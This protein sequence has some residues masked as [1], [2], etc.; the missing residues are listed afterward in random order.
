RMSSHRHL[1]ISK[2]IENLNDRRSTTMSN[3]TNSIQT[4]TTCVSCGES[5][6]LPNLRN[7]KMYH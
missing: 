3:R 6:E 5:I 4:T 2:R 7:H 1:S